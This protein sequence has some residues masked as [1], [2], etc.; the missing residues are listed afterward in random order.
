MAQTTAMAEPGHDERLA[1]RY[2]VVSLD[3]H[4]SP[5]VG[6]Y[7]DYCEARYLDDFDT[8][9]ASVPDKPWLAGSVAA[10]S[11][12]ATTELSTS[13]LADITARYADDDINVSV[14]RRL[15]D[16][17]TDGVVAEV[18]HHGGFNG[19]PI[20]FSGS[21]VPTSGRESELRHAGIRMYNRYLQDWS[22]AAPE[23]LIGL[24]HTPIWDVEAA[25]AEVEQL[26]AAGFRAINFPAPRPGLASYNMPEWDRLW[27]ACEAHGITLHTHSAFD[28]LPLEGPGA[29]AIK[30]A[31][32]HFVSRR[33]LWQM[34]FGGAFVRFP[35]LRLILTEQGSDGYTE[36]LTLLDSSYY[37]TLQERETPF[38][39]D[40][41]P[42]PPSFYLRRNCYVGA[43]FMSRH[44]AEGTIDDDI[45]ENM[46]WGRD[47]PHPE[48]TW[49]YTLAS[50]QKTFG[51]LP[52][53][54]VRAILG[55][56]AARELGLDQDALVS[57][58]AEIGPTLEQVA[59]PYAGRPE[60][61]RHSMGFRDRGLYS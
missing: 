34:T 3:S 17:D 51:G 19:Q 25:A 6:V 12:G 9:V 32:V 7:R 40:L 16:M 54:P 21:D 28:L 11:Y 57:V 22:S 35:E 50:M 1:D 58:A 59:E 20:P 18:I 47:Y 38:I 26:A 36:A 37:A 55:E 39:R 27:A 49:P 33:A 8:F 43:S 30:S 61:S 31:E 5:R 53:E 42:E 46:M 29:T 23:R 60:G 14:A 44:E 52:V 10:G 48:G 41:L 13:Y 45:W 24:G 2:L 4:L 56:T 15:A